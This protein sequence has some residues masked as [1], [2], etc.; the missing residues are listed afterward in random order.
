[1]LSCLCGKARHNRIIKRGDDR[2]AMAQHHQL[3]TAVS[4]QGAWNRK[5]ERW[6]LSIE[7]HAVIGQQLIAAVH[8]SD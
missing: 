8:T 7:G 5:Y 1:M 3:P 6:D 2:V 4:V